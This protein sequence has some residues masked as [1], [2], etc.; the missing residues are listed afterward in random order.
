MIHNKYF[1]VLFTGSFYS[2]KLWKPI[3]HSARIARMVCS[4]CGIKVAIA[5][6]MLWADGLFYYGLFF[7]A[8]FSVLALN[9]NYEGFR[10]L[11]ILSRIELPA[12]DP[13]IRLLEWNCFLVTNSYVFC[14]FGVIIGGILLV[15]WFRKCVKL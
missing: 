15:I 2:E 5:M 11:S 12:P 1:Y 13:S 14:L 4:L 9:L 10:C 8:L 7:I 3:R 6:K